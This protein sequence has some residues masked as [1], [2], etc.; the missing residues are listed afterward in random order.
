MVKFKTIRKR[1]KSIF[2]IFKVRSAKPEEN[3]FRAN[4]DKMILE[5]NHDRKANG[6]A[7]MKL[8]DAMTKVNSSNADYE[9]NISGVAIS[10]EVDTTDMKALD[11]ENSAKQCQ[12][13]HSKDERKRIDLILQEAKD[14][15]LPKSFDSLLDPSVDGILK[16]DELAS[17]EKNNDKLN[18]VFTP[19]SSCFNAEIEDKSNIGHLPRRALSESIPRKNR[20]EI[21]PLSGCLTSPARIKG[22]NLSDVAKNINPSVQTDTSPLT[23]DTSTQLLTKLKKKSNQNILDLIE[24]GVK[25]LSDELKTEYF[26]TNVQVSEDMN[27]KNSNN[28]NNETEEVMSE[29][30]GKSINGQVQVELISKRSDVGDKKDVDNHAK[31][32]TFDEASR[33]TLSVLDTGKKDF[34]SSSLWS[35]FDSWLVKQKN[36]VDCGLNSSCDSFN[37]FIG[38]DEAAEIVDNY[39]KCEKLRETSG[40]DT[41]CCVQVPHE[42]KELEKKSMESEKIPKET[43]LN[44]HTEGRDQ[45]DN[46]E[47]STLSVNERDATDTNNNICEIDQSATKSKVESLGNGKEKVYSNRLNFT[48]FNSSNL[49]E[50][51]YF[52][53]NP[54]QLQR[55][56][57]I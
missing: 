23:E 5:S 32:N 30:T 56:T 44:T 2:R 40:I 11:L 21:Y 22:V 25:S 50:T 47:N 26:H 27:D 49:T 34:P 9:V 28:N 20:K 31:R 17:G 54:G 1:F 6:S 53:M 55:M 45:N 39:F 37:F 57:E 36:N 29:L 14:V 4:G 41:N 7:D 46:I 8:K 51:S 12:I 48:Q 42:Y 18:L 52:T 38:I 43:F 33:K 3:G 13:S 24:P 35:S 10:C 16:N 19:I 15:S